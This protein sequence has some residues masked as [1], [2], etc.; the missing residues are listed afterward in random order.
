[1]HLFDA[2]YSKILML[3]PDNIHP[4]RTIYYNASLIIEAIY[5]DKSTKFEL[6]NLFNIVKNK[7]DINLPVFLLC[8][9]WLFLLD[10]IELSISGEIIY[11]PRKR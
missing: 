9:D 6:I 5:Q 11:V 7:N 8:L 2:K 10:I 4:E 3:L 1:M